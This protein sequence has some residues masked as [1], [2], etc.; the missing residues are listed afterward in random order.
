[1][2]AKIERRL[3]RK[4]RRKAKEEQVERREKAEYEKYGHLAKAAGLSIKRFKRKLEHGKIKFDKDGTPIVISK[5]EIKKAAKEAAKAEQG[6]K[7]KHEGNGI[8]EKS[9]K[10]KKTNA[11]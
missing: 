4:A 5:K 11:E 7:R 9:K 10:T 2:N 1:M 8:I 6:K 3:D